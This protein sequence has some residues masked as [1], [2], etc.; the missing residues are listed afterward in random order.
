MFDPIPDHV[1]NMLDKVALGHVFLRVLRVLNAT[2]ISP[3]LNTHL[4]PQVAPTRRTNGRSQG[5]IQTT[6]L[7]RKMERIREKILSFT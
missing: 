7:F 5:T 1:R 2:M 6:M 4:H 3:V